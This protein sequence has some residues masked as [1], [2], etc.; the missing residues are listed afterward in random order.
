MA[1]SEKGENPLTLGKKLTID[2]EDVTINTHK[3]HSLWLLLFTINVSGN[4]DLQY[5]DLNEIVARFIEPLV[6]NIVR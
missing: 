1:E 2:G 4:V 5:S 3:K 6:P